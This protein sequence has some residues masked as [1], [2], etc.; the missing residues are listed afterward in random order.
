MLVSPR[1]N[2]EQTPRDHQF[3]KHPGVRLYGHGAKDSSPHDRVAVMI[4]TVCGLNA[5]ATADAG[6]ACTVT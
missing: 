3:T 5:S 4:V 6:R 2:P 1:D